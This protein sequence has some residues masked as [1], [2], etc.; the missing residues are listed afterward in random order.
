M[1]ADPKRILERIVIYYMAIKTLK[2]HNKREQ[3]FLN[4]YTDKIA[5]GISTYANYE[6]LA[7][8]CDKKKKFNTQECTKCQNKTKMPP[9]ANSQEKSQQ[10][11]KRPKKGGLARLIKIIRHNK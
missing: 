1:P 2:N 5:N 7:E 9:R 3:N 8:K 6:I 10:K 11:E 4:A